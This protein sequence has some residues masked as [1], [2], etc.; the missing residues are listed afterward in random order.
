MLSWSKRH[1]MCEQDRRH[2]IIISQNLIHWKRTSSKIWKSWTGM[3]RE[4][5]SSALVVSSPRRRLLLPPSSW[6]N[7]LALLHLQ[8]MTK[9]A[10]KTA[11]PYL[12]RHPRCLI[13]PRPS[14]HPTPHRSHLLVSPAKSSIFSFALPSRRR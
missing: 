7:R 9:I 8:L 13:F 4:I 6:G 3:M 2:E 10:T 5:W 1:G 14:H 11:I 12:F